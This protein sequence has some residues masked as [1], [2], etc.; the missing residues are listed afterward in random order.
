M[1]VLLSVCISMKENVV[2]S[3][4]QFKRLLIVVIRS[5]CLVKL[6]MFHSKWKYSSNMEVKH[7]AVWL[8]W[9]PFEIREWFSLL[10]SLWSSH[11]SWYPLVANTKM[12]KSCWSFIY[13]WCYLQLFQPHYSVR[14]L[15]LWHS[16]V[17][18]V[19]S[20]LSRT[21]IHSKRGLKMTFASFSL[22]LFCLFPDSIQTR[23]PRDA[24]PLYLPICSTYFRCSGQCRVLWQCVYVPF[25][26]PF[27]F[28]C[29][30]FVIDREHNL[31]I[32]RDHPDS[33]WY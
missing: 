5:W 33:R 13:L 21:L 29:H 12:L 23:V 30:D 19:T 17:M 10:C 4:F 27:F 31:T 28:Q 16:P 32:Q 8:L 11:P 15:N 9:N 22:F 24:A 25:S 1:H 26:L 7:F 6:D 18:L 14:Y 20:P 2:C 3:I